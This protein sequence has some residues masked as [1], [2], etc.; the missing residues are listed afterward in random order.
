MDAFDAIQGR[1]RSLRLGEASRRPP[2]ATLTGAAAAGD[3]ALT[4][5]FLDAGAEIEEGSIGFASPLQA[6]AGAGHREVVALLLRRGA[7][8]RE[9]PHAFYSPL[10]AAAMHGHE[11]VVR[12][13]LD[14]IGALDRETGAVAH[15]ATHG[16]AACL[17]LLLER[18]APLGE[19]AGQTLRAAAFAGRFACVE[20][21][22]AA[23]V[24]PRHHPDYARDLFGEPSDRP[25]LPRD[26]ALE[27]GHAEVAALLDGGPVEAA[28]ARAREARA[29][30]R[31][32][33]GLRAVPEAFRP[34]GRPAEPVPLEGD[35]RD[36]EAAALAARIDAGE[37][38]GHLEERTPRGRPLLVEAA[39]AGL[40][41]VVDA[42]LRAGA[43]PDA[44]GEDG[45]PALYAAARFGHP[46]VVERLLAAGAPVDARTPTRH[47][48]L[49]AAAERGDLE[50]V[51]LLLAAGADPRARVRGRS[52][53]GFARGLHKPAIRALVDQA[54]AALETERE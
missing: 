19:H 34:A 36:A 45:Q 49:M 53:K 43:A 52:P 38:A 14:A 21:L 32:G 48:P 1:L 6:A 9:K 7:D 18:G 50:S 10:A 33:Q 15:A 35:A 31:E 8:P 24:D 54:A 2:P 4:R 23:G 16:Q 26:A 3:L 46:G 30:A 42:L 39:E 5:A 12:L 44:V 11:D 41:G 37:L 27:G 29:A 13:L 40:A 28:R 20:R 22:L 17:E 51:R 25:V 47:T